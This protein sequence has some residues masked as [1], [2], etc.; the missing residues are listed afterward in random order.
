[1]IKSNKPLIEPV[2]SQDEA[3]QPIELGSTSVSFT[4]NGKEHQKMAKVIM[5]FLP[6]AQLLISIPA[7]ELT[8]YPFWSLTIGMRLVQEGPMQL[9]LTGKDVSIEVFCLRVDAGGLTFTPTGSPITVTPRPGPLSTVMFHLFNFPDFVGPQDY[10]LTSGEPP[11]QGVMRCGR[12]VLEAG[13]WRI[14]IAAT[15]KTGGLVKSLREQGGYVITHVGKIERE[16]GSDFSA[17]HADSLLFCLHEFL[18]FALGRWVG[19][20]LPIGFDPDGRR[21][22]E[23]WDLPLSTP[24]AW[25]GSYSWFALHHAELFSE[26]F[27]GFFTLWND[28]AWREHLRKS[29]YWY[30]AA[31]ERSTGIGVDAGII[32]AQTALERLAWAYCVEHQR[33]VSQDAFTPR[34]LSS[35]N[36]LRMLASTLGI[37]TKIPTTMRALRGR[38]GRKWVDIP[39][40]IASIRNALVHPHVKDSHTSQAYYEAWNLSMWLLD[41]TL[42]RLC[43]YN[44]NYGNRLVER[45]P[46]T[47]EHVPWAKGNSER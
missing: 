46:G 8:E 38:R 42:L 22:F 37:T 12:V 10:A 23:Q 35:A 19:I 15:N 5:E 11:N 1:M 34:G 32:L 28:E 2:Y 29:L 40:A 3:N 7:E 45:Y 25:N 26:V 4:L 39:D 14:T 30:L 43:S 16:D 33:I 27:P 13:G 36:K 18:S 44:G 9:I 20:G 24:G 31:N 21:S 41:L 6:K 47:V 17:E